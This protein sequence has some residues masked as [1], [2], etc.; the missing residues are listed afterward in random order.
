MLGRGSLG[1]SLLLIFPLFVIY[2]IGIL[3]APYGGNGAD[4]ISNLLADFA[5]HDRGNFLLINAA[6]AAA[7]VLFVYRYGE[8]RA[9][10]R[11]IVTV[12]AESA[13]YAIGAV[14]IAGVVLNSMGTGTALVASAGAG[15]HEELVFR[16]GMMMG[17]AVLFKACGAKH[18]AAVIWALVISSILF[19]AAHHIGAGGEPFDGGVFVY[20]G[21]SGAVLGLIAY[22]RSL[23]HAVYTHFTYDLILMMA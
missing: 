7:F 1:T 15:F 13:G 11:T 16:L 10:M 23:A 14:V 4:L 3:V 8:A 22:Y 6:I 5:D 2:E 12:L 19:S 17:G 21:A 9:R 18:R 20:R